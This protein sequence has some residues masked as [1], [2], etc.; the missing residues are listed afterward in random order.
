MGKKK[1]SEYKDPVKKK[2]A[3]KKKE[4]EAK[5]KK[6]EEK[7]GEAGEGE[8][9]AETKQE[10]TESAADIDV[11][12]VEKVDDIGNGEP[13][14]SNW[15]YEVWTLLSLRFELHLLIHAFRKDLN[16]ADRPSFR[17]EHLAYYYDKYYKKS[18]TLKNFGV[19]ALADFL[20]LL[21]DSIALAENGMFESKL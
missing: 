1:Q 19:D 2:Y 8:E 17:E 6:V 20:E 10:P 18:F 15:V 12:S 21:E 16:D 7:D 14:F 3:Q 5:S 9:V 11:D 13:L 4:E